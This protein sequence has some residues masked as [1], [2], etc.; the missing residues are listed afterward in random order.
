MDA[1]ID[2][3]MSER[4]LMLLKQTEAQVIADWKWPVWRREDDEPPPIET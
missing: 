3:E 4:L 2:P 1:P